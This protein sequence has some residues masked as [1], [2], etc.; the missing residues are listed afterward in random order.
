MWLDLDRPRRD[1]EEDEALHLA[2]DELEAWW[3]I[4]QAAVIRTLGRA[5]SA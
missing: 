5:G 1:V 4:R 3:R 2:K